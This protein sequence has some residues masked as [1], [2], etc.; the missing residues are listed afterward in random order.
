MSL[1]PPVVVLCALFCASCGSS[2][3]K[4]E[5]P[6]GECS[7]VADCEDKN[8]CTLDLCNAGVCA[9]NPVAGGACA[10]AK[11]CHVGVCD[12]TGQ[13]AQHVKEGAACVAAGPCLKGGLC[14]SLGVCDAQPEAAGV[15]C[16]DGQECTQND[17]CDGAGLC[18]G[19][20]LNDGAA[21]DDG[22]SCTVGDSCNAAGECVSGAPARGSED[23]CRECSCSESGQVNCTPVLSAECVCN[24]YGKVQVVESFPDFKVQLVDSFPD[25]EIEQV[26]S[27][28][29]SPGRWQFVE[30]FP[31]FTIE[32]VDSFP[33][34]KVQWRD[35]PTGCD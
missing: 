1:R 27:F 21:C 5:P 28:P 31:D 17:L 29:D 19:S 16:D 9:H 14:S 7:V 18:D 23:P 34:F 33:D 20:P 2:E 22:D 12:N 11:V 26:L 3:S 30:S 24:L 13:C 35:S 4:Q 6:V 32:Y 25:L 10:T 15:S 8:P